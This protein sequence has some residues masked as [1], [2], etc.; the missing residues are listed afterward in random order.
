MDFMGFD[1]LYF[2]FSAKGF[3]HPAAFRENDACLN[4]GANKQEA[5]IAENIK[6][7]FGE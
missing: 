6:V 4:N 1:E 2:A 7:L 3:S 5:Q